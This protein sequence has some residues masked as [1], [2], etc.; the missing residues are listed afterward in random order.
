MS[1]SNNYY[2]IGVI[3]FIASLM[4][5]AANDVVSKYLGMRLSVFEVTMFRFLFSTLTILPFIISRSFLSLKTTKIKLHI[6]RGLILFLGNV[7]WTYGLVLVNVAVATV[8]TFMIPVFS[9]ILAIFFLEEK[10]IWQ[11]WICTL[12]SFSGFLIVLDFNTYNFN[13]KII[14]F[15]LASLCFA[16]LDIMNKQLVLEESILNMI[17]YSATFTTLFSIPGSLYYWVTPS[18]YEL[19][20]L[21][22]LGIGANIILFFILKAF[23]LV[24]VTSLA[25]YRYIELIFSSLIAYMVFQE[26]PQ[27]NVLFGII[28]IIPTT[29]FLV[30][31]EIR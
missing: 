10:F 13:Y 21:F 6:F 17:F 16:F 12:V 14:V 23:T 31:S 26:I 15:I 3:W 19:W 18:L 27:L 25:P 7:C 5:S 24:D 1:I 30:Y 9:L 28:I 11:R 8:V 22:L 4:T 20:L 2:L 29:L